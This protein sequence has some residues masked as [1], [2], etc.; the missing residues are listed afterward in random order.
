ME[1]LIKLEFMFMRIFRICI[2][3]LISIAPLFFNS[4]KS[5][6]EV[7]LKEGFVQATVIKYEVESCGYILQLNAD[8]K[9]M[10]NKELETEFKVDK[11]P[12][13]VK[14]TVQSKAK[15]TTCMAGKL[16]E[17]TEIKKR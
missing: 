5:K 11:M 8:E 10:P 6:K 1:I 16:A 4:C 3:G 12:V 2:V 14:Y 7:F 17:I 9:I 13:W 15:N